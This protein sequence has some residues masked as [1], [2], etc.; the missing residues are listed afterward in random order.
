MISIPAQ[1][2]SVVIVF[3]LLKSEICKMF[4]VLILQKGKNWFSTESFL[5]CPVQSYN[6][7]QKVSGMRT[8]FIIFNLHFKQN[9]K[10][11][12]TL[13]LT[14]SLEF[15]WFGFRWMWLRLHVV[16]TTFSAF[17]TIIC[18]WYFIVCSRYDVILFLSLVCKLWTFECWTFAC[19]PPVNYLFFCG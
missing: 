7:V 19:Y 5:V 18:T 8:L 11:Q 9:A 14:K 4:S 13:I 16:H 6:K 17:N 1:T 2:T 10:I 12:M 15:I 3:A